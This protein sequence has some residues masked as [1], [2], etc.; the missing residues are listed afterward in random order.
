MLQLL[1]AP[2]Q[3]GI[4]FLQHPLPAAE[5]RALQQ[6]LP[7]KRRDIGLTLFRL[8]DTNDVV[9]AFTPAAFVSVC[10]ILPVKHPA[11]RL[12]ARACQRLWLFGGYGAFGS[13]LLLDLSLSL[14]P[15]TALT[16]AVAENAS[17]SSPCRKTEVRCLDSFRPSRYQ[18]RRCR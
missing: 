16:L 17:R 11:A 10:S 6:R 13:S 9:P 1:S 12:L 7:P 15:P 14:A 5:Q 4:R 18:L 3:S 8:N 2:L